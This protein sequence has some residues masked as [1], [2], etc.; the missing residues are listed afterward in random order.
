M[1]EERRG[2]TLV[3]AI[4]VIAVVAVL[5]AIIVPLVAKQIENAKIGRARSECREIAAAIG[6]FYKDT[7]VWPAAIA[8]GGGRVDHQLNRLVSGS[9]YSA[10]SSMITSSS[11]GTNYGYA[12]SAN[13]NWFDGGGTVAS[14]AVD[15][16][17]NHLN[18]NKPEDDATAA[19]E[20][21]GEV[22]WK[23]PYMPP[24][25]TDPWGHYYCCNIAKAYSGTKQCVVIS[26]GPNG[27]FDTANN[28]DASVSSPTGDDIWE[29]VHI[30]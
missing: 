26:A 29:V 28:P 21:T 23:G 4:V 19:Y 20:T 11:D 17:D 13:D 25:N 15:I 7:G 6:R 30:R 22:C 9:S 16:F 1:K 24:I 5:S 18:M 10:M 12:S 3:E 27:A 14:T 2:F 8:R